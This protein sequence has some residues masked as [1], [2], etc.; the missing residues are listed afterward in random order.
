MDYKNLLVISI[1]IVLV[2]LFFYNNDSF[3]ENE[4]EN[5][6][7]I[8]QYDDTFNTS[9]QRNCSIFGCPSIRAKEEKQ[10]EYVG[11][12]K[13]DNKIF[14]FNNYLYTDNNNKLNKFQ[15]NDEDITYFEEPIIVPVKHTDEHINIKVKLTL[16]GYDYKGILLNKY[17]HLEFLLYEK[18][19]DKE[20]SLDE[21]LYEYK[22]VKILDNQYKTLFTLPPRPKIKNEEAVWIS[23]GSIQ[24]G[25]LV[26]Y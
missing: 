10:I 22:L 4:D 13:Q 19:F 25:P 20:S 23:Y 16:D 18:A 14:K 5:P 21:K 9:D 6:N 15:P 12:D 2:V 1:I 11:K 24:L 8:S 3:T 17:Y 26:F 7:E